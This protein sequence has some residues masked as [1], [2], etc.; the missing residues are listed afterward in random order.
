MS[1]STPQQSSD[2]APP[3]R[4]RRR[5]V[6]R[7]LFLFV[8]LAAGGYAWLWWSTDWNL[9]HAIAEADEQ[10]RDWRLQDFL[11]T[12]RGEAV[13]KNQSAEF[14]L[15]AMAAMA[16]GESAYQE[17][18]FVTKSDK[19][20]ML[21]DQ[22]MKR[23]NEHAE[24]H[25]AARSEARKISET[26]RG[27]AWPTFT[28]A[29]IKLEPEQQA[30]YEVFRVHE[31][32]MLADLERSTSARTHLVCARAALAAERFR[33]SKGNWPAD[34]NELIAAGFLAVATGTQIGDAAHYS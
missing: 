32:K 11:K 21:P 6:L 5:L 28:V 10:D 16:P 8:L 19:G 12:R 20:E 31:E 3:L 4:R 34:W 2:F 17:E 7:A 33:L 1:S 24:L 13:K 18:L 26:P 23:L 27:L 22:V 30:V 14:L 29:D 15:K 25:G 9:K